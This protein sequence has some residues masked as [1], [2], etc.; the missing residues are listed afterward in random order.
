MSDVFDHRQVRRAFSRAAESYES[1]AAL[2]RE[3]EARLLESLDYLGGRPPSRVLDVGSGVLVQFPLY[4]VIATVLTQ[5][6]GADGQTLAHRLSELFVRVATQDSFAPVIGA[7]SAVLGF[8]VPSGGGKWIIEAPYV[9]EAANA[10]RVHLGWTVQI[11][12]AAEALPN[13]INPFWMLPLLGVLGLKAR[14]IVGFTF[15]QFV[16]HVPL[17]LLMLWLFGLTLDYVPPM[18]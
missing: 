5:V 10:L 6:P 15:V 12:N 9:M 17:V 4:G 18:R 11:Y 14:D 1:A 2:Q 16:V 8:F 13:L 7:Y 3:V